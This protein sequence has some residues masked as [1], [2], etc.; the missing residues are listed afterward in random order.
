[1]DPV[2]LV[3][4]AVALG[5]S[6]GARDTAKQAIGDAYAAV[7][8]WITERYG[9]VSA[10]VEDLEREPWED[11]RRALLAKRLNQAGARDDAELVRLAHA[12]LEA[13]EDQAPELPAAVGVVIRRASAGGDIA[14]EDVAMDGGSGV[15][16]EDL[17]AGRD[18]RIGRVA[19]RA[20]QEPPHPSRAREQ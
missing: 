1:V 9:S 4:A 3:V 19:A 6:D 7:K 18:L 16:A 11:L 13:V 17:E 15:I 8:A 2:T 10:E 5:A 12:L 20:P 14:V